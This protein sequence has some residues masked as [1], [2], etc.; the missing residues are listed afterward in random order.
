MEPWARALD[1]RR[2]A[3]NCLCSPWRSPRAASLPLPSHHCV[4]RVVLV[5]ARHEQQVA[6]LHSFVAAG[7]E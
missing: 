6:L 2:L 5:P 7:G 3:T 1:F 4:S